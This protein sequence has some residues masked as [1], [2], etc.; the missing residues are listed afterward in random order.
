MGNAAI[1]WEPRGADA[2]RKID[3][4]APLSELQVTTD[5][6]EDTTETQGGR[7]Y[8]MRIRTRDRV[9]ITSSPWLSYDLW[10]EVQAMIRR[11][12]TGGRISIAE[13]DEHAWAAYALEWATPG[14]LVMQAGPWAAY[15]GT[16][17]TGDR[18]RAEGPSPRCQWEGGVIDSGSA[19]NFNSTS[20]RAGGVIVP[21]GGRLH[22][23]SQ[24]DWILVRHQAFWPCLRMPGEARAQPGIVH[25]HRR[26]FQLELTLEVDM[27]GIAAIAQTPT[28]LLNGTTDEGNPTMTSLIRSN[29]GL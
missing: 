1:W 3:L 15:G 2:P 18:W 29:G 21:E 22:D 28:Q 7:L 27:E 24:E 19:L 13:D 9:Q 16:V 8:S 25:K 12:Q 10:D 5:R 26:T 6:Q 23:W 11:L 14:S 4:G 20:F 17:A